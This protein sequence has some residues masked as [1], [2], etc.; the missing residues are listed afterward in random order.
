MGFNW[1][2]ACQFGATW[3][4]ATFQCERAGVGEEPS[5]WYPEV[6]YPG[7]LSDCTQCH[8]AGAVD[9]GTGAV[10]A[11]LLPST[12]ATGTYVAGMGQSPYV[13]AGGATLGS[14]PT[15]VGGTGLLTAGAG[16]TLVNS[17]IAAAC[18]SCHDTASAKSHMVAAGGSIYEAR[19]T[20]LVKKEQCLDCHG[21]AKPWAVSKVHK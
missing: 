19:S 8:V 13:A 2:A 20:A 16:T 14:G 12:V 21:A 18:F 3:N 5:I 11:S 17:P 6:E 4:A 1:H 10:A 15:F 7:K 9:F